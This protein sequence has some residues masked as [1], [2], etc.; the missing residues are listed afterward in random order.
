MAGVL[1][2]PA[3]GDRVSVK[4]FAKKITQGVKKYFKAGAK[5]LALRAKEIRQGFF[6]RFARI[7][8]GRSRSGLDGRV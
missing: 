2:V 5:T 8:I 7:S 1:R 6:S 4:N 3:R